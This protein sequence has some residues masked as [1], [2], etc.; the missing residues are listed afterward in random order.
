LT[1]EDDRDQIG[2]WK[3]KAVAGGMI[4]TGLDGSVTGHGAHILVIDDYYKIVRKLK[5]ETTRSS[6]FEGFKSNLDDAPRA[7]ARG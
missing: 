6:V 3:L 1:T 2:A 5:S 7:R 4:S